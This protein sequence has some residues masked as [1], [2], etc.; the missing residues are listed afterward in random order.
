MEQ[1]GKSG[2]FM[3]GPK[4]YGRQ[5]TVILAAIY[6]KVGGVGGA[7]GHINLINRAIN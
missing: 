1:Y 6:I 7:S 3:T 5:S 4:T 2:K